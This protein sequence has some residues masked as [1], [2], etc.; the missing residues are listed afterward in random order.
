MIN[1]WFCVFQKIFFNYAQD[2]Q[3]EKYVMI[4]VCFSESVSSR[5]DFTILPDATEVPVVCYKIFYPCHCGNK[6][7]KTVQKQ[8]L[9]PLTVFLWSC[10]YLLLEGRRI[11]RDS[12]E[13]LVILLIKCSPSFL[14][15]STVDDGGPGVW[16]CIAELGWGSRDTDFVSPNLCLAGNFL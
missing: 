12:L 10:S 15:I 8:P 2:S 9:L 13:I 5:S 6:L 16:K 4:S 11:I 1:Y 7:D 3:K 14:H